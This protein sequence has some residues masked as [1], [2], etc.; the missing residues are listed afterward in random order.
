MPGL[1]AGHVLEAYEVQPCAESHSSSVRQ[2]LGHGQGSWVKDVLDPL[3]ARIHMQSH[4]LLM[5][6]LQQGCRVRARL[7]GQA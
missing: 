1:Q 2:E 4:L 7:A 6:S 3:V 5:V